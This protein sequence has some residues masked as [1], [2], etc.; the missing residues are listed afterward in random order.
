MFGQP[1]YDQDYDDL[2]VTGDPDCNPLPFF[3]II[4]IFFLILA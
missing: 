3:I 4:V 1:D 2:N